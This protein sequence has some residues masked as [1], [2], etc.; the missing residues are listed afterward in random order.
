MRCG[1]QGSASAQAVMRESGASHP[2]RRLT[3]FNLHH[4]MGE[5]LLQCS[6]P[7]T[8][9]IPTGVHALGLGATAAAPTNA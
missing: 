1:A 6:N 5:Q 2:A 8:L 9:A 7:M 4:Q 3:S